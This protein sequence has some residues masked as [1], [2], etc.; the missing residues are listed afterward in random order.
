LPSRILL[1]D[2]FRGTSQLPSWSMELVECNVMRA[3]RCWVVRCCVKLSSEHMHG[4]VLGGLLLSRRIHEQHGCG[5]SSRQLLPSRHVIGRLLPLSFRSILW[6]G[7]K[8]LVIVH[9]LPDRQVQRRKCCSMPDLLSGSVRQQ[10]GSECIGMQWCVS[11]RVLLCRWL[12]GA[13]GMRQRVGVL[14]RGQWL[15]GGR[16]ARVL[17]CRQHDC[18]DAIATERVSGGSV[19]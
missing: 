12:Y 13:D 8:R 17:Q 1:S 10:H 3:V 19:L 2:W 6:C 16:V 9:T 18:V 7:H 5:V 11:V 4:I 14:S 15:A